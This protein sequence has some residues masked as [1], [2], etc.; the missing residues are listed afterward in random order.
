MAV[1]TKNLQNL[2]NRGENDNLPPPL[3]LLSFGGRHRSAP[4]PVRLDLDLPHLTLRLEAE[5][6]ILWAR[7]RHQVRA[8]YTP[9]LMRDMRE[10][11]QMLRDL[12][13]GRDAGEVPF[14]W[15]VWASDAPKRL[16][17]SAGPNKPGSRF[18]GDDRSWSQA[19]WFPR[20]RRRRAR[21]RAP[22]AARA[23]AGRRCRPARRAACGLRRRRSGRGRGR[24]S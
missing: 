12:Y 5:S 7:M 15:L 20:F 14:R 23:A 24:P 11:Q 2:L 6:G 22:S 21:I 1:S 13:G 18:R 4:R 17:F 19:S 16:R 9:E 3:E 10:T 8:C